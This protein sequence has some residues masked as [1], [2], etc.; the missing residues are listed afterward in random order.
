MEEYVNEEDD[1][2]AY[3]HTHVNQSKPLPP[4][5]IR[6]VLSDYKKH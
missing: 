4:G 5:D 3:L 1:G 2:S 6:C